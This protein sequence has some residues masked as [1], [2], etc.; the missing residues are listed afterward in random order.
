MTGQFI[1]HR[2]WSVTPLLIGAGAAAFIGACD[3][4]LP[5]GPGGD[6][7]MIIV[8]TFDDGPLPADGPA[9]AAHQDPNA[10]ALP[11]R[12]ILETLD[13]RGVEAV[14]YIAGPGLLD[15]PAAFDAYFAQTL[16]EIAAAGHFVGYHAWRHDAEIWAPA[17]RQSDLVQRRM[18]DDLDRLEELLSRALQTAGRNAEDVLSPV[19]RQPYGGRGVA[20]YDGEAVAA[21]RG[22]VYHGFH[23]DS[24]DWLRHRDVDPNLGRSLG[25]DT[26]AA[27][28]GF[29][30]DRLRDGIA[31]HR[32][33][34]VVDVLF[35]VNTLTSVH[36]D[37]WIAELADAARHHTGAEP[38]FVVPA[39]YLSLADAEIDL[40]V[41]IDALGRN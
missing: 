25:A 2:V 5:C 21:E 26:E 30:R 24:A 23:V 32:E 14:F 3:S 20:A 4:T 38:Q 17:L 11:L 41:T 37:E 18:H 22:W 19:F 1:K 10:L 7:P 13:R 29:V 35:H 36:L 12:M 39:C 34:A 6:A 28:V 31:Q 16:P 33:S 15:A 40:S 9:P 8:L 27:H